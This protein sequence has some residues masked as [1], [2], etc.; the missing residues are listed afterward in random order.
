[1]EEWEYKDCD[2]YRFMISRFG[3]DIQASRKRETTASEPVIGSSTV[4]CS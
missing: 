4:P 1:M 3:G 2:S